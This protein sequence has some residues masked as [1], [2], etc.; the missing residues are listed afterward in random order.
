[1][2]KI[3]FYTSGVSL[4][5]V[6][7]V[8]LEILKIINKKKYDIKLALQYEN[9]NLF[10]NEIPKEVNFKYML[11]KNIID[12]TLKFCNK[13]K[14]IFYKVAYNIMLSY[15]KN[16]IKK[17]FLKFSSDRD[18]II[19]FK[20]GDFLKLLLKK[21]DSRKICWIHTNPQN[22]NKFQKRKKKFSENIHKIDKIVCICED[23]K[24]NLLREVSLAEEKIEVIYNLFDIE[25][26]QKLSNEIENLSEIEKKQLKE[27]YIVMVA[28]LEL[29]SKDF[30]TLLE[31]YKDL[32]EIEDL[33]L[34]LIGDG[35]DKEKI[36]EKIKGMGLNNKVFLLGAK[37]NPYP[38]IK[39]AQLLVHSSKF[40]GFGLV[41]VEA[42]ILKTMVVATDC[43]VGPREILL[44]GEY[45]SLVECENSQQLGDELKEL[46]NEN[47]EKRKK[48]IEN[49]PK[50]IS[51]FE[52]KVIIKKIEKILDE[53]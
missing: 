32:Y 29:K 12:K 16:I 24:K 7:R 15:E 8:I 44:N 43:P 46:L 1:M 22:I 10:E 41:I 33:K 31:A 40:E 11:S 36:E 30:F 19:D 37:K 2:K 28:R 47:S 27:N 14:N 42:I 39:N 45:G 23:M 18:I 6:E 4:G 35:P 34:Y 25:K 52:A 26:I 51:R 13:K 5:G 53:L 49:F 20:S 21:K 38:W 9:E 17:N 3:L 48:Y 50:A